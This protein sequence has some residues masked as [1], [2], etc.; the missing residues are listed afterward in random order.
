MSL[1]N[2]HEWNDIPSSSELFGNEFFGDELMEMYANGGDDDDHENVISSLLGESHLPSATTDPSPVKLEDGAAEVGTVSAHGHDDDMDKHPGML[3]AMNAAAMDNGLGALGSSM[4]FSSPVSVV[5]HSSAPVYAPATTVPAAA[6]PMPAPAA[7]VVAAAPASRAAA[8]AVA[9]RPSNP[10]ESATNKKRRGGGKATATV[11]TGALA[12]PKGNRAGAPLRPAARPPHTAPAPGMPPQMIPGVHPV[13]KGGGIPHQIVPRPT[14]VPSTVVSAARVMP[15]GSSSGMMAKTTANVAKPCDPGLKRAPT[16]ADFKDVAQAAV[17]SLIQNASNGVNG[18]PVA[19]GPVPP[20][21]KP[22]TTKPTEKID[23][24]TAH[25]NALT[26]QNWVNA[27]NP[28]PAPVESSANNGDKTARNARRASLSQEERAKQN[29]DRNREHA[30]N[31]RLRKKAYVEELKRTLTEIVAQRDATELEKRH[32]AQR[33]REQRE[34]RFRVMEEFLK[35]RG[36]NELNAARWVAIL[37]DG[38]TCTL[39]K[40]HYR[41]M[42]ESEKTNELST[43]TSVSISELEQVLRGAS[44]AM[45]DSQYLSNFLQLIGG[46][47]NPQHLVQIVFRCER[48]RFFMDGNVTFMDFTASTAGIVNKGVPNEIVFRGTMRASFSPASNKLISVD[49]MFDTGAITYQLERLGVTINAEAANAAAAAA[50]HEADALLDSLQ[51]P[52][53][54]ENDHDGGNEPPSVSSDES[55]S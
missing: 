16:E 5:D 30:R 27:C 28:V 14:V 52:H 55:S 18:V 33:E 38:F 15:P 47:V 11:P 20:M 32:N 29:R 48:S 3:I 17:T 35:L 46:G 26:S 31:T 41:Q 12:S 34:V 2:T 23:T 4:E 7:L 22:P 8:P 44:A 37:E 10:T 24:S 9:K 40:T 21:A 36:R 6:P 25:I 51:M 39:P 53:F 13:R 43:N 19:K 1:P 54:A 45:E 42:V 50:A 49:I